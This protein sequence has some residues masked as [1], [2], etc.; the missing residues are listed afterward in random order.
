[1]HN[2]PSSEKSGGRQALTEGEIPTLSPPEHIAMSG[3]WPVERP[4]SWTQ[5]AV[6]GVP[7]EIRSLR[8]APAR[9]GRLLPLGASHPPRHRSPARE[10]TLR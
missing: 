10:P 4:R 9:A 5:G 1:M 6:L 2:H 8:A 7:E 3:C